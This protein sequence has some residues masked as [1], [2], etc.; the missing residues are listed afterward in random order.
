MLW[1][2]TPVMVVISGALCR[3]IAWLHTVSASAASYV[4]GADRTSLRLVKNRTETSAVGVWLATSDAVSAP[5]VGEQKWL[6]RRPS[7]SAR[8][9]D[10]R[11]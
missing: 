3:A 9:P 4:H 7:A 2:T 10:P 8:R 11:R 1:S 6:S 5:C